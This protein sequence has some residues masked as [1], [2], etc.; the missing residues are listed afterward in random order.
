MTVTRNGRVATRR[1][2][3]MRW[4]L[5]AVLW[6]AAA[7][8]FAA[9]DYAREKR[10]ADEIVPSVVVG[11]AI[12]LE[13]KSGHR[14]LALYAAQADRARAVV[15]VHGLGVNPDWGLINVL[16]TGLADHGYATL[17]IQM[18]VLAA[19]AP[20]ER[21][22]SLL[23]DAAERLQIAVDFLRGKGYRQI[24]I[25][26]HSLGSRMTNYFLTRTA[27]APVAAWV[28]IG[29]SG[30]YADPARLRLPVLDLYGERDL[31]AVLAHARS[32]AAILAHIP[33]SMQIEVPGTSH[34]FENH[35]RELL[36]NTLE[37]L[38]SRL[39]R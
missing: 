1:A 18:P 11:D 26:S 33:G 31:P 14:F 39:K 37:F 29:L 35:G 10:W 16:R 28:A 34:F 20:A 36:R 13:Q 2:L 23:P 4:L 30:D 27:H 22:A 32:R 7:T 5:A 3:G 25:V 8:A 12:Y 6:A 21:Y 15:V 24:A 17:S 9:P 19:D 38:D